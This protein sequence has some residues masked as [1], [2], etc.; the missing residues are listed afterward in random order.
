MGRYQVTNG[1]LWAS[2]ILASAIVGA[3]TI[4]SAVLLPGLAA[5]SILALAVR[6][7][8]RAA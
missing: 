2:A 3:P 6:P 5:V 1:I 4:L 8:R 7:P